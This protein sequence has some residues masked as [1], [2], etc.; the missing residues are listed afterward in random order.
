MARL[1][2]VDFREPEWWH[3]DEPAGEF[4]VLPENWDAVQVFLACSTQWHFSAPYNDGKAIVP[5]RPLGLRYE[6][7]FAVMQA[8]GVDPSDAFWRVR[9]M[10]QA[11]LKAQRKPKG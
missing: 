8:M 1:G 10:E 9:V 2:F 6:A 7:L 5:S 11:A 4:G 3:E